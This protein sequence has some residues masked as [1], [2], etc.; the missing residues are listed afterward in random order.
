MIGLQGFLA[1]R[2]NKKDK[3]MPK[4]ILDIATDK[5]GE[6]I[7]LAREIERAT[8]EFNAFVGALNE[9]EAANLVALMWVG[10]GSFEPEDWAD[11]VATA[12]AEATTPTAHY[13]ID[14]PLL[15]DHLENGLELLGI[16]SLEAEDDAY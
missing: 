13:L 15:A 5:V 10:R 9:D 8:P 3:A 2:F 1:A 7:I 11:A 4:P 6:I 14:T 16:S 12:R